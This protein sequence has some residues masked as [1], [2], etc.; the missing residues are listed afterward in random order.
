MHILIRHQN[1]LRKFV[2]IDISPRDGSV[3]LVLRREGASVQRARW[4]SGS[5]MRGPEK[6]EIS[7]PTPKSKRMTIHQSGRVNFHW[8]MA[9]IFLEPLVRTTKVTP[10]CG[11]RVPSLERLDVHAETPTDEDVVFDLTE[12]GNG[13]ITFLFQ[14]GPPKT[15]PE[16]VAVKLAY[17][18]EGYALIIAIA[19]GEP[20]IPADFEDHF[21]TF[22]PSLGAFP[23]QQLR[24]DV[25]L[26]TYHQSRNGVLSQPF[27]YQPNG[28]GVFRLFFAV[29]MRGAPTLNIEFEDPDLQVMETEI[30]RDGRSEKVT[31]KFK[32]RNRRTGK[33]VRHPVPIRTLELDAEIHD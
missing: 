29:P 21:I 3:V 9:P 17:E 12:L 4:S 23:E 14:I 7:E 8:G 32:V 6:V 16:G 26:L 25:A 1:Q 19:Q 20:P 27:I 30:E 15:V 2:V 22:T 24:E 5:E 18:A 31:L 33:I 11:Y 10:L 28:E 13:P